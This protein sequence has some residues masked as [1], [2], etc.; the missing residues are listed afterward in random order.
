VDDDQVPE[1]LKPYLK[2]PV[3]LALAANQHLLAKRRV[4]PV[5]RDGKGR[6][7]R[8]FSGNPHGR[9]PGRPSM[10]V[11]FHRYGLNGLAK[12]NALADDPSLSPGQRAV[13]LA[14]QVRLAYSLKSIRSDTSA[15]RK[16]QR[17]EEQ[18]VID[19]AIADFFRRVGISPQAAAALQAQAQAALAR[20]VAEPAAMP[21][22]PPPEGASAPEPEAAPPQPAGTEPPGGAPEPKPA[23]PLHYSRPPR[24]SLPH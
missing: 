6:I 1:Y 4:P 2:H 17:L 5:P 11:A 3:A 9:P 12:L 14:E 10:R 24:I 15:Q 20:S 13:V 23:Q 21:P 16:L 18:R 22:P 19:E 7:M 8:G